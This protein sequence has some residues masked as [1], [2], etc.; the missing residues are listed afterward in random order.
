MH[1]TLDMDGVLY[2]W[3]TWFDKHVDD[4]YP[5][6]SATIPRGFANRNFDLWAGRTPEEQAAITHIFDYPDFYRDIPL[7]PNAQEA[8]ELMWSRGH[9]VTVASSPWWDNPTCLQ[10]KSNAIRRDFGVRLQKH[11]TFTGDKTTLR[12]DYL[13]DDKPEITGEY[14]PTWKQIVFN[15]PYNQRTKGIRLYAWDEFEELLGILESEKNHNKK[16]VFV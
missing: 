14:T 16:A 1:I 11:T 10:D 6:F 13:V 4:L 5:Q 3:N 15:Q 2:D 9:H 7:M 12:G 8:V